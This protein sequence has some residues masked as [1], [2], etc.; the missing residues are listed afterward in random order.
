MLHFETTTLS[1]A[2]GRKGALVFLMTQTYC[3]LL[4]SASLR[5]SRIPNSV[6]HI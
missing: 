3:S 4:I 2:F 5:K 6:L 1:N